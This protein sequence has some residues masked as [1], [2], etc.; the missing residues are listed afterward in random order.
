MR[1]L[2][3]TVTVYRADGTRKIVENCQLLS[4]SGVYTDMQGTRL[5]DRFSLIVRGSC[6]LRPGDR[7]I[8]GIGPETVDWNRF[9]PE[10]VEGVCQIGYVQPF[11]FGGK[12]SHVEAGGQHDRY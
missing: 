3:Q 8:A 11:F 12:V 1:L 9:L 7:V 4:K 6:D 2:G 10:T 5:R